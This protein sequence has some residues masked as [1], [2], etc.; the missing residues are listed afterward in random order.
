MHHDD[1]SVAY[2]DSF[3]STLTDFRHEVAR[4]EKQAL[5]GLVEEQ[6]AGMVWL[7]DL[8]HRYDGTVSAG[9]LGCYFLSP[10]RGHMARLLWQAARH[11]WEAAGIT[12]FFCAVHVANRRSQAFVTRGASFHRV[13]RFPDF[14]CYHGRPAD[15]VIYTLHIEDMAL[16]WELAAARAARQMRRVKA[17]AP[18]EG[19]CYANAPS[20]P[21]RGRC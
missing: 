12:H 9:W 7:H 5:L 3:P 16:A 17:E 6:V 21:S 8:L 18:E 13:G 19:E 10:Y 11:H 4:G 15:L 2:A 14:A 1:L 20:E